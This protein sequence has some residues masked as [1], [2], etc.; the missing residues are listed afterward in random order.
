MCIIS[1]L[2]KPT[3]FWLLFSLSFVQGQT[4]FLQFKRD[5]SIYRL[6]T[7][8]ISKLNKSTL[9]FDTIKHVVFPKD[10]DFLNYTVVE[11][12]HAFFIENVGGRVFQL[13]DSII[14]RVDNSFSHKMSLGSNLFELNDTIF[15]FGGYGYWTSN[16]KLSFFDRDTKEWQIVNST[17]GNH[18]QGSFSSLHLVHENKLYVLGGKK[19]DPFNQNKSI[20]NNHLWVFDFSSRT[21]E[22]LGETTLG[23]TS[24]NPLFKIDQ[25]IYI[26]QNSEF[27]RISIIDNT[28]E[29]L[30]PNSLIN[31]IKVIS[32]PIQIADQLYFFNL[33]DNSV[34]VRDKDEIVFEVLRTTPLY[35][36]YRWIY[37]T[38]II[39]LVFSLLIGVYLYRLKKIKEYNLIIFSKGKFIHRNHFISFSKPQGIVLKTLI[40]NDFK[41][42]NDVLFDL[43]EN[44][45][46]DRSQNIRNKNKIINDLNI[47]LK[48]I[49]NVEKDILILKPADSDR[50]M[51][52]LIL[53]STYFIN[54]G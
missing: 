33:D 45:E 7:D 28:I 43:L 20:P 31:K 4:P 30:K 14:R 41:I 29:Q 11:N 40:K 8:S 23:F 34:L 19:V 13:E 15:R 27:Y 48:T 42:N 50:R 38:L 3:V 44:K 47:K 25:H 17:N 9:Q 39:L 2:Y 54:K 35:N 52:V 24:E 26:R 12:D 51:K 6:S 32:S 16:N 10:F 1:H 53:K 49:L 21:W 22:Q 5:S 46:I 37:L 36:D 18:P